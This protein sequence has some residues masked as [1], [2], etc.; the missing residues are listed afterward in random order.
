M[1]TKTSCQHCETHL[2]FDVEHANQFVTCPNCGKETRLLVSGGFAP[3]DKPKDPQVQ[4][5]K[6]M[7]FLPNWITA[8][9]IALILIG[10]IY[11]LCKPDL[12]ASTLHALGNGGLYVFSFIVIALVIFLAYLLIIS[13]I[14]LPFIIAVLIAIGLFLTVE[15]FLNWL[16]VENSKEGT[17]LQQIYAMLELVGGALVFCGATILHVLLKRLNPPS[18][19]K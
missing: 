10:V 2:E 5:S 11:V 19:V 13:G 8:T 15:G 17:V 3:G 9:L 7:F 12:R 14:V 6:K 4:L 18:K 1:I 16:I